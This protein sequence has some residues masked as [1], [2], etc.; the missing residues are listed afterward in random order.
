[1]VRS[2]S[3]RSTWFLVLINLASVVSFPGRPGG[4]VV[5]N[6]NNN[7]NNKHAARSSRPTS[8]T[9]NT[10]LQD[11]ATV[12]AAI[13]VMFQSSPYTAAAITC[14]IKASSADWVAQKRQFR[15]REKT[16]A[17]TTTTNVDSG[18][19]DL[20]RNVAFLLYGA[21]YQGIAQEYIYNHLYPSIFGAGTSVSVVLSKV[22]FDLL[23][24]T[25][26]V[27]LPIAYL[28]KAVIYKYSAQEALRRYT[29]DIRNHGLLTKY[30]ML[31]G[32]VQCLTFSIIP[33]HYRVTF[34]A[35]VSFFW[36]IIL[37]T[38]SNK[39]PKIKLA[40]EPS[41]DVVKNEEFPQC[42]LA[43]GLTCNIDG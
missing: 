22:L 26:L 41:V 13:D 17:T 37:S 14:G 31:W 21:I 39:I 24:Q 16:D 35:C 23:V 3:S 36:V 32:P 11:A 25:T 1:M 20:K 19:T 9:S 30:F 12:V 34:I 43:D 8:R 28:T 38:I 6:H 4:A 5:G 2:L 18:K 42:E 29:D 7:N 33:E 40:S 10:L 15:K 27:T